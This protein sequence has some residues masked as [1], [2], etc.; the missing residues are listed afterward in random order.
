MSFLPP[1]GGS[2]VRGMPS[3]HSV[4]STSGSNEEAKRISAPVLA[5][6]LAQWTRCPLRCQRGPPRH[7]GQRLL[8]SND[9]P[10][11]PGA[12]SFVPT[13]LVCE[14]KLSRPFLGT[15]IGGRVG[16]GEEIERFHNLDTHWAR[17]LRQRSGIV[18]VSKFREQ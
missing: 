18:P 4:D 15:F 5:Q 1:G 8:R 16:R 2:P 12:P 14:R 3:T 7:S 10:V 13:E 9:L 6:I 17:F 11:N